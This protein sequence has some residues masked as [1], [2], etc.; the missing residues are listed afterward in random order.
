MT[1]LPIQ[2]DDATAEA[3]QGADEAQKHQIAM[4]VNHYVNAALRTRGERSAQFRA[5]ADALGASAQA[6]G[7]NDELDAALLRGDFDNAD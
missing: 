7:W 6:N 4:F 5:A 1:T 3:F 2:I